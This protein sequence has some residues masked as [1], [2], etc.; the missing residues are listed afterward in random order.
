MLATL[1]TPGQVGTGEDWAFEMKW[2]GV[3]II[4]ELDG[5]QVRLT[6]RS[7]RDE[8]LRYPDLLDDLRALECERAT[9]D[10]EIVVTD[11]EGAPRFELL[12]PRINLTRPADISSAAQRSPAQLILFDVLSLNGTELTGRPYE[13][14]RAALERL[15]PAGRVQVPPGFEGDLASALDTS[16]ALHLEGVVAKRRGSAYSP[17]TRSGDWLKIKH[18]RTQSV[19]VGGWRPGLGG[20]AGGIGSL[21]VGIPDEGAIAYA[22]RVGSGFTDAGLDEAARLLAPLARPDCPLAGVPPL[23]ARDA[24]WVEPVLVGEVAYSERTSTGRL[25]HPVWL[26]WRPD[27]PAAAVRP[28]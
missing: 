18:R 24:S 2:D 13:Q 7:G 15:H 16:L 4:V 14:R 26:G 11:T 6:G 20:R 21:L 8:T 9:L 10:G 17:G 5:D 28:E 1:A 12:Q 19:V 23:D 25:R 3:R 27:L 22:G